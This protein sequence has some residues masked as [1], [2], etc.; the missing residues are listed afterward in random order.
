MG[1]FIYLFLIITFVLHGVAFTILGIRRRRAYYFFLTGTFS[2][3]TVICLLKFEG[4]APRVQG[5]GPLTP[6]LR[7]AAILCTFAYLVVIHSEKV[8]GFGN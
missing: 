3:L 2:I 6:L 8:H 1:K 4:W 5:L 7:V